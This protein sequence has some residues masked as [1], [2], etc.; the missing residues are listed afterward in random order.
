[1]LVA[2]PGLTKGS[3]DI[4]LNSGN[5][6][7]FHLDLTE[8]ALDYGWFR[9][10]SL[11]GYR[12][13]SYAE[14]LHMNQSVTPLGANFISGTQILSNDEF[15]T[16]NQFHGLDMGLRPQFFFN[17]LAI[18]FVGKVAFGN[19]HQDININ[20]S[21]TTTVPGVG[22]TTDVGG[23]Y[24]LSSNIGNRSS[25][26]WYAL[27]EADVNLTWNIRNNVQLRL[28]YSVLLLSGLARAGNQVDTFINPALFPP[29][30]GTPPFRPQFLANRADMWI[31]SLNIGLQFTY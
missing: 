21:Q 27:P 12:F 10:D 18:E 30:L 7:D 26:H 14:T 9:L 16:R 20:G 4:Q 13:Y 1:M 6:Y 31:Q 11:F 19:L 2:F 22:T 3:V 28:G 17:D 23:V 5:F 15:S 24:A 8:K 29:S 25:N